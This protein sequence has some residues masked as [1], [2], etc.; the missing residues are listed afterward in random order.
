[1]HAIEYV[2]CIC[3]GARVRV[4]AGVCMCLCVCE[5]VCAQVCACVCVYACA[6]ACTHLYAFVIFGCSHSCTCV[7]VQLPRN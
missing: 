4:C 7:Q 5:C 6:L 1:M 2:V 3:A